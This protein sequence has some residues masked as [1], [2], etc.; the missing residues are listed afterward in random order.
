MDMKSSDFYRKNERWKEKNTM[1]VAFKKE[2]VKQYTKFLEPYGFKKIKGRQ[3]YFVRVINNEIIHVLSYFNVKTD[4]TEDRA[5]RIQAGVVSKYRKNM[6]VFDIPISVGNWLQADDSII[7]KRDSFY[8]DYDNYKSIKEIS[9]N[10]VTLIDS[11]NDSFEV[12]KMIIRILD[13]INNMNSVFE[14]YMKYNPS[15][16]SFFYVLDE[17]H[18]NDNESLYFALQ[19]E[20]FKILLKETFNNIYKDYRNSTWKMIK[21]GTYTESQ[22]DDWEKT[23]LKN[24]ESFCENKF[25]CDKRNIDDR[26]YRNIECLKKYDIEIH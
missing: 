3:P 19:Q 14:Y 17:K 18:P 25:N 22:I 24:L 4:S 1:S 2:F 26:I 9:Y 7:K 5:F 13:D 12:S 11:I 10:D 6:N 8:P 16:V 21:N 20:E 23:I 15:D